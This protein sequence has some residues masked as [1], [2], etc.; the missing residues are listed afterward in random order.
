M[1]A[2]AMRAR[3]GT[4]IHQIRGR[5]S[6]LRGYGAWA[7]WLQ[8]SEIYGMEGETSASGARVFSL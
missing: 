7:T 8:V 2:W 4:D 5:S 6:A 3:L 1:C